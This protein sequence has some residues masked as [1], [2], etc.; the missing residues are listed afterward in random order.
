MMSIT[1]QD[2]TPL[3]SVAIADDDERK[4]RYNLENQQ[5]KPTFTNDYNK[6]KGP[7]FGLQNCNSN[8]QQRYG[9]NSSQ[10]YN[11]NQNFNNQNPNP[12]QNQRSGQNS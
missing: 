10:P 7:N 5:R 3:A 12:G 11:R 2:R 6:R 8:S 4:R 1:N 9:N